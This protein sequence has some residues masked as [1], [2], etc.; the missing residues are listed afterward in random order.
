MT[1]KIRK[2]KH[3]YIAQVYLNGFCDQ[4]NMVWSY[5]KNDPS[6]V[7]CQKPDNTAIKKN[8]YAVDGVDANVFEDFLANKIESPAANGLKTLQLG[9]LPSN[10]D[11]QAL[12]MFFSFML[13][14]TPTHRVFYEKP[15]NSERNLILKSYAQDK[16]FFQKWCN[17]YE[18]TNKKPIANDI[19]QLRQE[20][21]SGKY[22]PKLSQNFSLEIMQKSGSYNAAHL[23]QMKW[24]IIK[25]PKNHFFLTSDNPI[26]ITNPMCTSFCSPGLNLENTRVFIPISKNIGLFMIKLDAD[27]LDNQIVSD[28]SEIVENM[29]KGIISIA[30]KFIFAHKK[31]DRIIK[32]I[33]NVNKGK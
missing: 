21:L 15:H 8:F 17:D 12:A 3:H 10:G 7:H 5:H 16:K 29:N 9:H 28:N 11:R 27:G 32:L 25:A 31:S 26:I 4:N 6:K 13:V 1:N 18:N 33:E 14:R 30:S 2:K 24:I 19:E 22:Q 20:I 23:L